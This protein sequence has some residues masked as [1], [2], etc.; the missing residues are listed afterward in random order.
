MILAGRDA[1]E[2]GANAAGHVAFEGYLAGQ[3]AVGS[4]L[5][6]GAQH[7]VRT[8][9][10]ERGLALERVKVVVQ[11]DGDEA[12]RPERAVFGGGVALDAEALEFGDAQDVVAGAS[13]GEQS[14]RGFALDEFSGQQIERR[15]ADAA[16]DEQLFFVV[17]AQVKAGAERAEDVDEVSF[18]QCRQH[19][20][21]LADDLVEHLEA[22]LRYGAALCRHMGADVEDGEGPAQQRVDAAANAHHDELS[23]LGGAEFLRRGQ[24]NSPVTRRDFD[25]G[26]DHRSELHGGSPGGTAGAADSW[27][28]SAIGPAMPELPRLSVKNW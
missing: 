19:G 8:A 7:A 22:N 21:A 20:R 28:G 27:R 6:D 9:G 4:D 12:L 11:R 25:V 16:A 5:G 14:Y 10:I 15:Q 13:S 23:G 17:I 2:A 18:V 26:K 24:A 3:P 1:A